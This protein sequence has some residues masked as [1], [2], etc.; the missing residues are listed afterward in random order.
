M[1]IQESMKGGTTGCMYL[2]GLGACCRKFLRFCATRE[3]LVQSET[4]MQA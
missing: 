2:G 3:L 4:L 1:E